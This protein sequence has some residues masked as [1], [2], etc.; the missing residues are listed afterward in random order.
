MAFVRSFGRSGALAAIAL[1]VALAAG[2]LTLTRG[3]SSGGGPAGTVSVSGSGTATS[4]P[5]ELTVQLSIRTV[6]PSA[7]AALARDNIEARAVERTFF[8]AG[9]GKKDVQ[10]SGLSVGPQIDQTGKNVGYF[11]EDDLTVVLRQLANS[12]AVT[13][14]AENAAGNDVAISGISYSITNPSKSEVSARAAA[15]RD[16]LAKARGLAAAAGESVGAIVRISDIAQ[17][18]EPIG[19]NAAGGA[20]ARRGGS[21]PLQPGTQTT[22]ASVAVVFAL[23]R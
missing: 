11:A 23:T 17:T 1:A 12:G 2:G 15:M 7:K 19:Y 4:R 3:S 8:T 13:T 22:S 10:T 9:V 5:D 14:A 6:R 20:A 21:V 18:P 16:A